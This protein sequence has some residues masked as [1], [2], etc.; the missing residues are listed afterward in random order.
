MKFI[1]II[2]FF[3]LIST[4]VFSQGMIERMRV[5]D[6]FVLLRNKNNT[7]PF[8]YLD[9]LKIGFYSTGDSCRILFN[10][11]NRYTNVSSEIKNSNLTVYSVFENQKYNESILKTTPNLVLCIFGDASD[12]PNKI[13]DYKNIKAIIYSPFSDS[14][15]LDYCGQLL[16]GGIGAKGK[17]SVSISNVFK[18]GDGINSKGNIRFKYTIPAELGLDSLFIFQ[19]IDSIANFAVSIGATPGCQILVAKNQVIIH[20]SYG[21]H[22][23]D[24]IVKVKNTDLYD[25]A[26]I[27]KIAASAPGLMLLN[28]KNSQ[29]IGVL[30]FFLIKKI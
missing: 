11:M 19:K 12:I 18:L 20:K 10:S 3:L 5:E 4:S 29:N 9:K 27:T 26:S 2:L 6:S 14:L 21:Y 30:L 28:Q 8:V 17:L 23:F 7:I 22:T 25:L 16:F 24:S 13:D 1:K 15:A